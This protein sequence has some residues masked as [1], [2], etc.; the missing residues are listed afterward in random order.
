[1]STLKILAFCVTSSFFT[2]SAQAQEAKM[3]KVEEPVMLKATQAQ[4]YEVSA[5]TIIPVAILSADEYF[6]VAQVTTN[7]YDYYNNITIPKGSR[8][9]GR[10][11]EN[12]NGRHYIQWT[13]LQTP[14][15]AGTLKFDPPINA[16][17]KNG[18]IGLLDF[19]AGSSASAI[20]NESFLVPH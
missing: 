14:N 7:I 15:V 3:L 16:T 20:P 11:M 4:P 10:Y 1:M 12:K 18:S 17:T 8:L 5:G 6:P 19:T 9:I 2:L 13:G